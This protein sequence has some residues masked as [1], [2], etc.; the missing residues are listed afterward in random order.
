MQSAA[1]K[2]VDAQTDVWLTL[3]TGIHASVGA[4]FAKATYSE[5]QD[6]AKARGIASCERK[7][8]LPDTVALVD[9]WHA[10]VAQTMLTTGA[11]KVK[12]I[13]DTTRARIQNELAQ[14]VANEETIDQ[15]AARL[16]TLYLDSLIPN[17]SDVISRTEVIGASNSASIFGARSTGLDLDKEWIATRDGRTREDHADAD[18]Q[19]VGIDDLFDVGGVEMDTPGD[20]GDPSQDCNCRCTTGWHVNDSS[21]DSSND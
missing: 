2:A 20:S 4:A 15:L 17:R 13:T 11:K 21:N 16:D 18:G 14:G 1:K 3:I 6:E 5:L 9:A 10:R 7:A 12:G 19:R 8:A